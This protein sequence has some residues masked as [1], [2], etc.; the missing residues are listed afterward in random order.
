[1]KYLQGGFESGSCNLHGESKYVKTQGG[2][3]SRQMIAMQ[4]KPMENQNWMPP[5]HI[6]YQINSL[7]VKEFYVQKH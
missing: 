4:V 3:E 2:S 5:H 1:M 6:L 7:G